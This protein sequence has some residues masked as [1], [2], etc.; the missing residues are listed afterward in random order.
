MN[1]PMH[2]NFLN[3]TALLAAIL[4]LS[5]LVSCG[6]VASNP[7]APPFTPPGQGTGGTSGTEDGGQLSGGGAEMGEQVIQGNFEQLW[8]QGLE[9][10]EHGQL[11]SA[12]QFF[13]SAFAADPQ[14]V[15]AALAYA[16][17]D[18]M[19]DHRKFAVLMHPGIDK[20]VMNTPLIG[21]PELFPN[22]Y[23]TEDSYFLRLSA[24]GYRTGLITGA[25]GFPI[26]A[27]VDT[28]LIF[29][30]NTLLSLMG[31]QHVET[32]E[33]GG[34]TSPPVGEGTVDPAGNTNT[35]PSGPPPVSPENPAPPEDNPVH[36]DDSG[37]MGLSRLEQ[38]Q[39]KQGGASLIGEDPGDGGGDNPDE[40]NREQGGELGYTGGGLGGVPAPILGALPER[41]EALTEDEWITII[42]E[43]R[44][45]AGREGADIF[46]S[47]N[48]YENLQRFHDG[49]KEH[50]DN[51]ESVRSYIEQEEG[52]LL[53]LG[54][55]VTDGTAKVTM[56]FDLEDFNLII[57]HYKLIDSLLSY[58]DAYNHEINYLI[59]G[60]EIEDANGDSVLSPDEYIPAAPFGT[61][62]DEQRDYLSSQHSAFINALNT[63]T[64]DIRPSLEIAREVQAGDPEKKELFYLSSFHRN[65]VMIED[66]VILLEDIAQTSSS[67]MAIKLSSGAEV[68]EVVTVYDALYSNPLLDIRGPLPSFDFASRTVITDEDGNWSTDPTFNGLFSEGLETTASYVSTG[69]FTAVVYSEEMSKAEG[70]ILSI[71]SQ[72]GE[73]GEDG[74]VKIDNV[75]INELAGNQF[76]INDA[77]GTEVGSGTIRTHYEIIPLFDINRIAMLFAPLQEEDMG[78]PVLSGAGGAGM[79]GD[80][81]SGL[82]TIVMGTDGTSGTMTP[83]A[84]SGEEETGDDSGEGTEGQE[85]GVGTGD[86]GETGEGEE[87][88]EEEEEEEEK[89]ESD[90]GTGEETPS[91]DEKTDET[92]DQGDN[93]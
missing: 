30:P 66:W 67:G 21:H 82:G 65:F 19:R 58:V 32:G 62:S 5:I 89:E 60:S 20:L 33:E 16:I 69:R 56:T 87:G 84:D 51:L 26:L 85:D 64:V 71:G 55:N 78:D 13:M 49:I 93:G 57:D 47:H 73:T 23:L 52:Y 75:Y 22:P 15:D 35:A 63:L 43:Y 14:S 76:T 8:P 80:G 54:F 38:D 31:P 6:G 59:P 44:E 27:P 72:N 2:K 9:A 77:S 50:I 48:F 91:E 37:Q 28:E 17:S 39:S 45:A 11:V 7:T 10:M 61:L 68:T 3:I 92:G 86:E 25:Q 88:E 29:N 36:P 46:P 42:R 81:T 4:T 90:E 53:S 12:A 74:I 70:F 40:E 79:A 83:G 24:L 34:T 1:K 18:L 41:E